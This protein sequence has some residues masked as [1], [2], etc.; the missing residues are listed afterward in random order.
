M[1]WN[2]RGTLRVITSGRTMSK[3]HVERTSLTHRDSPIPTLKGPT[4][5]RLHLLG[6]LAGLLLIWHVVL[7]YQIAAAGEPQSSGSADAAI[8]LGAAIYGN[9]PSPVFEERIRHG[10]A[11][12]KAGRVRKLVCTGG[13]GKGAAFAESTVARDYA[14][15]RGV[16]AHAVFTEEAS[17]TTKQN[18]V[19]ARRLMR[20][21]GLKSALIVTDPLHIKRSLRMAEGLGIAASPAPTPTSRYR[22]WRS[23][24]GFLLREI[25]F[26]NVY[27]LTGQ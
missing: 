23:K 1:S 4:G 22:S 8:V 12:F 3:S 20:L 9:R 16:P 19:E 5:K 14:L 11:L 26:Y 15:A 2:S 24:T 27:L 13:R 17:R 21:H 10:I 7:G 25:Y 18:L 6:A